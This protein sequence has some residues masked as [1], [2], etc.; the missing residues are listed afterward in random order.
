MHNYTWGRTKK[1]VNSIW[2]KKKKASPIP[3]YVFTQICM[4][5]LIC[6]TAGVQLDRLNHLCKHNV[7]FVV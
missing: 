3:T 5:Q 7:Q 4:L 6:R 1:L 2:G